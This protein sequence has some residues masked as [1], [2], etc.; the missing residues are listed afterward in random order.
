MMPV[1]TTMKSRWLL[2]CKA[3]TWYRCLHEPSSNFWMNYHSGGGI[4]LHPRGQA[5]IRAQVHLWPWRRGLAIVTAAVLETWICFIHQRWASSASNPSRVRE[6]NKWWRWASSICSLSEELTR[7]CSTLKI[8][9]RFF[10]VSTFD[11]FPL[12][13]VTING[14]HWFNFPQWI[15]QMSGKSLQVHNRTVWCNCLIYWAFKLHC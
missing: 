3:L 5:L 2:E 12:L 4:L 9:P 11:G 1:K 15:M 7:T 6:S 8:D 13:L 14:H 10:F